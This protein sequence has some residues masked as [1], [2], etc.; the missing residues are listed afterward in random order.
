MDSIDNLEPFDDLE[1]W[2]DD[3]DLFIEAMSNPPNMVDTLWQQAKFK[4]KKEELQ[5][6]PDTHQK[7]DKYNPRLDWL[8][9]PISGSNPTDCNQEQDL[10]P[11]PQGAN[12]SILKLNI[13]VL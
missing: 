13:M 11:Q 3:I 7:P 12:N 4:E 2:T 5:L 6:H 9:N 1:D 10:T 8:G